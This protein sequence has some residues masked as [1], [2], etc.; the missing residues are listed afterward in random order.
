MEIVLLFVALAAPCVLLSGLTVESLRC[1]AAAGT[2]AAVC[3]DETDV[4][5]VLCAVWR[6][7]ESLFWNSNSNKWFQEE[8]KQH[9][10]G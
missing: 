4:E 7:R 9:P 6:Q 1:P 3:V 10:P 2:E 5:F 8:K